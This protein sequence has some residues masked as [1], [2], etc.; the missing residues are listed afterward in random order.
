MSREFVLATDS[1]AYY[2][3]SA[4]VALAASDPQQGEVTQ[5]MD[6]REFLKTAGVFVAGSMLSR[7]LRRTTIRATDKLGR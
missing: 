5:F 7:A 2:P 1:P 6:K 3:C 4:Q